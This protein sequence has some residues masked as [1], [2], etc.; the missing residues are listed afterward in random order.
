MANYDHL[1]F[2]LINKKKYL[3]LT[4]K[5]IATSFIKLHHSFRI[6]KNKIKITIH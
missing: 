6:T 2:S 1:I 3:Y 4:K 5:Y